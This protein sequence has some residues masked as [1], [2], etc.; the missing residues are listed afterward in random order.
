MRQPS[1]PQDPEPATPSIDPRV[2]GPPDY[3]SLLISLEVS[4]HA[5]VPQPTQPQA[6]FVPK[7]GKARLPPSGP[8]PGSHT[9]TQTQTQTQT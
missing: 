9:Q 2:Y 7:R 6:R 4:E 1:G 3:R 8:K 5:S